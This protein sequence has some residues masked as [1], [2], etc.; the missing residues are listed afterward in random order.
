MYLWCGDAA[1]YEGVTSVGFGDNVKNGRNFGDGV[2][3]SRSGDCARGVV[4][5][6]GDRGVGDG[7]VVTYGAR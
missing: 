2:V 3:Y 5:S 4:L 1:V 7:R 6:S